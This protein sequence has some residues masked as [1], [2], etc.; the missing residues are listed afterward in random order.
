MLMQDLPFAVDLATANS[1]AH[2]NRSIQAPR[3]F[4]VAHDPVSFDL[5]L[6]SSALTLNSRSAETK[7]DNESGSAHF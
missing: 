7:I 3:I 4:S 1:G 5:N 2:P 6:P